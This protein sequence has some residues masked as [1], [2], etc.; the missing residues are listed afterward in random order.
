[1]KEKRVVQ[2]LLGLALIVVMLAGPLAVLADIIA[3]DG[4]GDAPVSAGVTRLELGNV[5]TDATV[6]GTARVAIERSGGI[7]FA[8]GGTVTISVSGT[9]GAG[10]SATIGEPST[11]TLPDDWETQDFGTVSEDYVVSTVTLKT[12]VSG[13]F[14]G[15]VTYW[16]MGPASGGGTTWTPGAMGVSATVGDCTPSPIEP[17]VTIT[18][19]IDGAVYQLGE[20][21]IADYSCSVDEGAPALDICVGTVDVGAPID[22]SSVGDKEFTVT[23]TDAADTETSV[24]HTYSVIDLAGYAFDGFFR[25]VDNEGWNVTR[26]GAAIPMRFSLGGYRGMDVVQSAMSAPIA[27][28]ASTALNQVDEEAA[29]NPGQSSLS[30]DED[31]DQYNYVWKTDQSW[32]GTCRAFELTL[33][34]GTTHTASFKFK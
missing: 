33:D 5:C 16:A 34:D 1:M 9:E 14:L 8:N 11:I 26:A 3:T 25:P 22:T 18:T 19:P 30:Y 31:A 12:D 27:C 17:T 15:T 7:T 23:A 21:V 6:T 20:A 2:S 4:D 29:L 32:A 28:E 24:T 13:D 10:L